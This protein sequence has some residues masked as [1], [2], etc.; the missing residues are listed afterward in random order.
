MK[1]VLIALLL[2]VSTALAAWP[3]IVKPEEIKPGRWGYGLTTFEG[4]EPERFEIKILGLEQ[5]WL[6]LTPVPVAIA[7]CYGGPKNYPIRHIGVASGMSGSP[8]YIWTKRGLKLLGAL[9]YSY[10]FNKDPICGITLA[11]KMLEKGEKDIEPVN[12][13]TLNLHYPIT[14]SGPFGFSEFLKNEFV[15]RGLNQVSFN[16]RSNA[17][18][19][20]NK[21]NNSQNIKLQ[22][23]MP[24]TAYLTTG[25]I[26]LGAHGTVT[27]VNDETGEFYAF[28]HPFL[29]TGL[30][31]MPVALDRVETVVANYWASYKMF[32]TGGPII[33]SLIKDF[34]YG[35]KGQIGKQAEMI[36]VIYNLKYKDQSRPVNVQVARIP[37][38]WTN[39]IIFVV[40]Y[41][42]FLGG[43]EEFNLAKID[44]EGNAIIRLTIKGDFPEITLAS[45]QQFDIENSS[46]VFQ[47][48]ARDIYNILQYLNKNKLNVEELSFDIEYRTGKPNRLKLERAVLDKDYAAVGDTVKISLNFILE[49]SHESNITYKTVYNLIVPEG[50]DTG[51][52]AIQIATGDYLSWSYIEDP[53]VEEILQRVNSLTNLDFFIKVDFPLINNDTMPFDLQDTL[54]IQVGSQSW[55]KKEEKQRLS[56]EIVIFEK[57]IPPESALIIANEILYL[58]IV[59]PKEAKEIEKEEKKEKPWWKIW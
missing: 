29:G 23:A 49:N 8:I 32:E 59:T 43:Y 14:F 27:M 50:V 19:S 45:I 30:T 28:G 20:G 7:K 47:W 48:Y 39:W 42:T 53:T 16:P 36:P 37:G 33:G 11:Q 58:K 3:E 35:V 46:R 12:I 5:W 38:D 44:R 10:P 54:N 56:N 25:D 2:V 24:I 55:Q 17:S 51:K 34:T 4:Y 18:I 22:P 9:A 1:K 6:G 52:V 31:S 21:D 41:Y 57:I 15:A 40:T 26:S 13:A